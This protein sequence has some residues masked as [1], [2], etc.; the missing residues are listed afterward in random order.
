MPAS[1]PRITVTVTPSVAAVLAKFSQVTGRSQSSMVG[2]I[3]SEAT[4]MMTKMI[5]VIEAAKAVEKDMAASLI[6]P[7]DKA[8]AHVE[9]QLG[10]ALDS[11][12]NTADDLLHSVEAVARR[13]A[14][15][16]KRSDRALPRPA[17][18]SASRTS[19]LSNRGGKPPAD[20]EPKMRKSLNKN[21][22]GKK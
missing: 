7:F 1:N 2:D 13:N 20:G 11:A 5:K 6:E 8:Q 12:T 3:L 14:Q 15:G 16:R 10:L 4:P 22:K 17:L 21:E 19:P 18:S 9:H